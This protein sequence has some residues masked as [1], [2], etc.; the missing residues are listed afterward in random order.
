MLQDGLWRA[1]LPRV[2]RAFDPLSSSELH[3]DAGTRSGLAVPRNEATRR[4]CRSS[5]G[6]AAKL[7]GAQVEYMSLSRVHVVS[8]S[9]F[10]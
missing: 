2:G 4:P 3:K 7:D 8:F 5:N 9:L 10:Q 1:T 6:G